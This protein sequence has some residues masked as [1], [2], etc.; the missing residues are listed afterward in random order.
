MK[1]FTR[2]EGSCQ[3]LSL[4]TNCYSIFEEF[5]FCADR[6]VIKKDKEM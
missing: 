5:L 4:S 3:C 6:Y 2:Y 1:A